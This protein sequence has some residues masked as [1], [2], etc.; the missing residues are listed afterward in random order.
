[1]K[2]AFL[3]LTVALLLL[4]VAGV[5]M[6]A[7]NPPASQ[8]WGQW[9]DSQEDAG[10]AVGAA[11]QRPTDEAARSSQSNEAASGSAAGNANE[12]STK[13]QSRTRALAPPQ[14]VM[15]PDGKTC[16]QPY[17]MPTPGGARPR[18]PSSWTARR[19]SSR[20]STRAGSRA[21]SA[22]SSPAPV[23]GGPCRLSASRRTTSR[24]RRLLPQPS[25]RS[26]PTRTSRFGFSARA[27]T[28]RSH[29][30]TRRRRTRRQ[31]TLNLTEQN[32]DQTQA[33]GSGLPGDRP[34]GRLAT[35]MLRRSR[36]RSKRSR[37]TGTSP[38]GSSAPAT[39]ATSGSRTTRRRTRTR[40]T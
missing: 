14:E 35:R 40:A 24:T 19:A 33:G 28:A 34:V 37:R 22:R 8:G 38:S 23:K 20:V 31:A 10:A 39:A 4:L 13:A 7:A 6:A 2:R 36:R 21:T 18:L 3:A 15:G 32:A 16:Y 29:S 27:T 9:A 1:M 5:G 11:P 12:S 30:R 17:P 25:R 26:R